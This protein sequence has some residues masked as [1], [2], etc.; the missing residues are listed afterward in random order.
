MGSVGPQRSFASNLPRFTVGRDHHGWWV[1]LDREDRVG[2]LFSSEEAAVHFAAGECAHQPGAVCR[3]KAG[4]VVELEA[5]AADHPA[6]PVVP[7]STR[8]ARSAA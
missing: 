1:V 4:E 5:F 3:A 2:G 8:Q 7:L 6:F